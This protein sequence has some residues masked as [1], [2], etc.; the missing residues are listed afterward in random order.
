MPH[1]LG[2]RIENELLV[3]RG[4]KNFYGQ[5]LYFEDVTYCPY[6][7]EAIDLK[8]LSDEEIGWLN[9]Y[10]QMVYNRLVPYLTSEEQDW[11]LQATKPI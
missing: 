4:E 10:H 11:L 3:T 8:Y 6:D 9:D 5:F 2:I 7:L 1:K